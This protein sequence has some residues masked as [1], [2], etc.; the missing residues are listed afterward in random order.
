MSML[1]KIVLLGDGGVG[2]TALRKSY[3]GQGFQTKYVMTIGADFSVKQEIIE[4]REWKFQIWDLAGQQRFEM[5][6]ALYY[7]GTIGAIL[8]FDVTRPDSLL[9]LKNWIDE[10][11][12]H[13]HRKDVPLLIVANKIDIRQDESHVSTDQGQE[14]AV[15]LSKELQGTSIRFIETSAKTG[16]NVVKAFKELAESIKE[17]MT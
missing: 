12:I 7:A 9:N 2:K 5:V 8:V 1:A 15:R 6:R 10:L 13:S 16:L 3:L 17:L 11:H 14:F 4:G